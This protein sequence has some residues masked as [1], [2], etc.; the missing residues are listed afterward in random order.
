LSSPKTKN[1]SPTG[2]LEKKWIK[3]RKKMFSCSRTTASCSRITASWCKYWKRKKE[4]TQ[5]WKG[6]LPH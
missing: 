3:K 4:K 2:I 1:R 6:W 5:P